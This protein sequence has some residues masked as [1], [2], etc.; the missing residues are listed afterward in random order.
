[1]LIENNNK[2]VMLDCGVYFDK[3][4]R[5]IG[6]KGTDID[7]CL[8]GH[9]HA[10]HS[11]AIIDVNKY[12]IPIYSSSHA[13]EKYSFINICPIGEE[14]V[15]RIG[16]YGFKSFELQHDEYNIGFVLK[17]FP[18]NRII[19]YIS[20]TSYIKSIPVGTSILI[21]ECNYNNDLLHVPEMEE[22]FVRV[23]STHMSME[24]LVSYLD[25]IDL[26]K[27]TNIVVVHLSDTNSNENLIV[28]TLE[29]KTGVHVSAARNGMIINLDEV[30]F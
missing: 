10:D 9:L 6:F 22:R 23:K 1:M 20:D 21:I 5:E 7:F 11:R 3:V 25:K 13:K 18:T 15:K 26:S 16:E 14:P 24:R 17:H 12:F 28:E 29:Q 19:T 30:P 27:L 4:L 8:L 2:Y